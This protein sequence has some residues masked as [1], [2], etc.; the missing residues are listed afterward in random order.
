MFQPTRIIGS[1]L[2]YVFFVSVC[3]SL[4][5]CLAVYFCVY[6][7][8]CLPFMCLSV[9]LVVYFS[10]AVPSLLGPPFVKFVYIS[11]TCVCVLDDTLA[12]SG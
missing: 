10:S 3:V 2:Y 9:S 6:M 4:C 5:K 8:A 7:S 1:V 12:L 11:R